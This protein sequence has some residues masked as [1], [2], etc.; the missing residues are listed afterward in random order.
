MYLKGLCGTSVLCAKLVLVYVSSFELMLAAVAICS[1]SEKRHWDGE[2]KNRG[3]TWGLHKEIH[4][5]AA[6]N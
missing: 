4:S 3:P 5:P 1:W 2:L 6:L